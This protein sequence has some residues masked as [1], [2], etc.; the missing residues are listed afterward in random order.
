MCKFFQISEI[1]KLARLF[2]FLMTALLV[3][4]IPSIAQAQD[5]TFHFQD[6]ERLPILHEGRVKPLQSFAALH[7][8][9]YQGE[10]GISH[11][12]AINWLAQTIFDPQG[13]SHYPVFLVRSKELKNSIRN[14]KEK[15]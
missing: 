2:V 14:L 1:A 4:S 7:Y 6:F 3:I 8:R 15:N 10:S 13:A 11:D 5:K 12:D 9:W